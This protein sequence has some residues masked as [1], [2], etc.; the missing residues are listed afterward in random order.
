MEDC[1]KAYVQD[2]AAFIHPDDVANN[3]K[4]GLTFVYTA[5]HGV[6][7]KYVQSLV[8]VIGIKMIPVPEQQFPDPD[9]PTVK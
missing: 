3:K 8:D 7:Y 1:L 9:F 4:V 2:I 5:M 6:G